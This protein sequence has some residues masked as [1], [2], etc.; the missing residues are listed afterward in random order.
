MVM[1]VKALVGA[2]L[3]ARR[4]LDRRGIRFALVRLIDLVKF[5]DI[6]LH[7]YKGFGK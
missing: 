2:C 6:N 7:T 3:I 5:V 4:G 1:R